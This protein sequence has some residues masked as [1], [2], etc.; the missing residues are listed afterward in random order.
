VALSEGRFDVRDG[1]LRRHTARGTVI[2]AIYLI[3]VSGLGLLKGFIVAAYLTTSDYGIWGILVIGLGTLLWLKEVGIG[4][5]YVQQ[6]EQDQ[7]EA[8]QKAFTLELVFSSLFFVALLLAVPLL[9]VIY[10]QPEL[11]APGLALSLMVPAAGLSIAIT[12]YYRRMQFVRQRLLQSFDPV[13]SFV[14]TL[15][16]AVA[17][18]GYWSL[19]V[20]AL[21]GAWAAALAAW[22]ACPYPLRLRYDRGTARQYLSF[23]WPLFAASLGSI[24]IAQGAILIGN[25]FVGLAGVGAI[26][27]AATISQFAQRVDMIVTGTLYPAICA[28]RERVDLLFE[29]FVKSNRLALMW[30][31]PFG[32]SLALFAGD[33]IEFGI[34]ERWRPALFLIQVFGLTAA[35]DQIGFNWDAYFRARGETR[36]IAVAHVASAAVFLA[37]AIPLT[38]HHGLDGFA[39][40]MATMAVTLLLARAYYL[41]R[42]F[43]GFDMLRHIAR[44]VAPSLPAVAVI[45]AVRLVES[46]ERTLGMALAELLVY[47]GLTV[48]A[49]WLFERSLLREVVGYLRRVGGQPAPT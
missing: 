49:T 27:L 13:V 26:A 45:L 37:A 24:V 7:E 41:T 40:A 42:L 34:G 32:L 16:L 6:A 33:V 4:D 36:P 15:A 12:V 38:A 20:G 44:A 2:N 18:A 43:E 3:G 30:G 47:G 25:G 19:V 14:V 10:N 1:G 8:F 21:A 17:G 35:V 46:G 48:A 11:I 31:M 29:S 39:V 9:A 22:R 5:K 28:V 23:S